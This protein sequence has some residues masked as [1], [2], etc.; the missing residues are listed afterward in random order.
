MGLRKGRMGLWKPLGV[1][2]DE[3]KHM[4]VD[5]DSH[6]GMC[7]EKENRHREGVNVS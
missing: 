5:A 7:I 6:R 1:R 2:D 3:R 4:C